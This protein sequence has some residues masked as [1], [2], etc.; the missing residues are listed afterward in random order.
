MR[1]VQT[2]VEAKA[3]FYA[4]LGQLSTLRRGRQIR[5]RRLLTMISPAQK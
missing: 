2:D 1:L 5:S 3:R 4:A